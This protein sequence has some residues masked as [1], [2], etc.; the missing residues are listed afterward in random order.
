MRTKEQAKKLYDRFEKGKGRFSSFEKFYKSVAE[1][2]RF[3]ESMK[4]RLSEIVRDDLMTARQ[5]FNRVKN[6]A[7]L[8]VANYAQLPTSSSNASY[9]CKRGSETTTTY[10]RSSRWRPSVAYDTYVYLEGRRLCYETGRGRKGKTDV[11]FPEGVFYSRLESPNYSRISSAFFRE[12]IGRTTIGGYEGNLYRLYSRSGEYIT[13]EFYSPEN[14]VR[15]HGATPHKIL[16]EIQIKK[17]VAIRREHEKKADK[18]N[19]RRAKLI[20]RLVKRANFPVYYDDA[21][22]VGYCEAGINAFLAVN[23]PDLLHKKVT[24]YYN[25]RRL[26]DG[27]EKYKIEKIL[28]N[29]IRRE[30]A[31]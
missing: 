24:S 29:A 23:A 26:M 14:G 18:I 17:I 16:R 10:S 3:R 7:I 22:R 6:T 4:K 11:Y 12:N 28:L 30:L 21:R 27:P 5:R 1:K 8:A 25:V 31:S 2:Q 20:L 15:D 13:L 9:A 19:D